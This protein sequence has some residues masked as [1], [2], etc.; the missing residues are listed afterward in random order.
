MNKAKGCL[1]VYLTRFQINSAA[2][3]SNC[4][5]PDYSTP[6]CD[7]ANSSG[8]GFQCVDGFTASP[9]DSP[10]MC[11][12]E[13]PSIVCNGQCVLGGS[14]PS[15]TLPQMKKRW[16]GSGSCAEM[17]P[18]WAACGVFG[19]S[20]RAWECINTARDLESCKCLPRHSVCLCP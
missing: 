2:A 7:N 18:E 1:D 10:T 5:Y 13:A 14:C 3:D 17:G 11:S 6:S 4:V 19:G 8:C 15:S 9:S 16:V 12:C 20:S